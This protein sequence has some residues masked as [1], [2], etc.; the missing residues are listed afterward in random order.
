MKRV[1]LKDFSNVLK[2]FASLSLE[3][4]RKA[5]VSGVARSIPDLIAA[6]PV[7]TGLYAASWDFLETETSVILGNYAPYAGVIEFGARPHTPP[8]APLLAWAKRVTQS[9]SQPP[10]YDS[11]VWALARAVQKKIAMY[12]Q[13]PRHILENALPQIVANIKEELSRVQSAD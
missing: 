5:V 7:D 4:K 3:K 2:K 9:P 13:E 12:G 10:D 8:I 1:E 6:S 11:H